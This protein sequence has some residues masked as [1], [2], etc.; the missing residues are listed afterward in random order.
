[1]THEQRLLQTK[2]DEIER[3]LEGER[4]KKR[5]AERE[6]SEMNIQLN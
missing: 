1:L 2:I 5:T 3:E 4:A 6:L